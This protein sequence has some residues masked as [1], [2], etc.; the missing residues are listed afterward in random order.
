MLFCSDFFKYY[1]LKDIDVFSKVYNKGYESSPLYLH[2]GF[3]T[4]GS[5]N[6]ILFVYHLLYLG[7]NTRLQVFNSLNRRKMLIQ[8]TL[9]SIQ[10]GAGSIH[11]IIN[12]EDDIASFLNSF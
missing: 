9:P 4:N 12:N 5:R 11:N 1:E 10:S 3:C 7:G 6:S 8:V 2:F